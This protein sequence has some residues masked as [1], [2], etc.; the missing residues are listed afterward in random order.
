MTTKLFRTP[1]VARLGFTLPE[2]MVALVILGIAAAGVLVPF[3]GGASV[4]A[5]GLRQTLA[6][7]LAN[8]LLERIIN[9]PFDQTVT[10]WGSY[11]EPQG[12]VTDV[13]GVVFADPLYAAFSREASCAY[14]YVYEESGPPLA[15]NFIRASVRVCYRGTEVVTLDR[16][17]TR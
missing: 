8:D 1:S 17:I 9:T 15:P 16:L 10:A 2:A 13:S 5:E 11:T 14:V 12:Q 4:Q 3:G 7:K 6:A